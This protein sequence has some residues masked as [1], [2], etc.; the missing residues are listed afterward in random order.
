MRCMQERQASSGLPTLAQSKTA[1]QNVHQKAAE[2]K[3]SRK[4]AAASEKE[5]ASH[6]STGAPSSKRVR[7]ELYALHNILANAVV[8]AASHLIVLSSEDAPQP[9]EANNNSGEEDNG[10]SPLPTGLCSR[11]FDSSS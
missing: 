1:T 2:K 5:L 6:S 9:S 8:T 3:S 7:F 4:R 11:E 10:L